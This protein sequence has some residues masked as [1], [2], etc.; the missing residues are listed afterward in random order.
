ML[1]AWPHLIVLLPYK[2]VRNQYPSLQNLNKQPIL[3]NFSFFTLS[4]CSYSFYRKLV[5]VLVDCDL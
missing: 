4:L 5:L 1:L 2:T 3:S